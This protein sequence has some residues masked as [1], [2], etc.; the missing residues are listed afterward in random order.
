MEPR[1]T[2]QRDRDAATITRVGPALVLTLPREI[3]E[4]TLRELRL[5]VAER[6]QHTR[7]GAIVIE[8]SGMDV[9]DVA[10]FAELSAVARAARWFGARTLLVGLS[11]G[12]VG[13]LVD[14]EADTSAFE[15]HLS[16]DDAL[17]ALNAG[18][19]PSAS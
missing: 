5:Q 11:A 6:L 17:A 13:Y 15:P 14:A 4:T 10:E 7:C 18:P 9:I 12:I 3:D 1:R 16:L 8:A 19:A 2:D